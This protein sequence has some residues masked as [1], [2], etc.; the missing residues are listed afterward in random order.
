LITV[1]SGTL[2]SRD[3]QR[4]YKEVVGKYVIKL[5]HFVND[6]I[7]YRL[8]SYDIRRTYKLYKDAIFLFITYNLA[9]AWCKLNMATQ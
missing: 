8:V 7:I 3:T 9:R 1:F 6:N 5:F 4:R 2:Q